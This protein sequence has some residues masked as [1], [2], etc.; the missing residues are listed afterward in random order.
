MHEDGATREERRLRRRRSRL[1]VLGVA[2]FVGGPVLGAALVVVGAVGA[3]RDEPRWLLLAAVGL[4]VGF[5]LTF[6]GLRVL[7]N[8]EAARSAAPDAGE[9]DVPLEAAADRSAAVDLSADDQPDA[10]PPGRTSPDS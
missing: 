3:F 8:L 9:P 1:G 6:A 4:G 7:T 10:A 2:L 5:G